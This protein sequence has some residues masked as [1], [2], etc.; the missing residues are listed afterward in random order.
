MK[1][2]PPATRHRVCFI[3]THA[4]RR[5]GIG[6]FTSDLAN[7]VR[8][9]AES[10]DVIAINEPGGRHRYRKEV[11]YQ[12]PEKKVCAYRAA[13][14]YLNLNEYSI[15]C[16]Q[17]EYGI[18]GGPA[19]EN[20][21]QL[22]RNLRMPLVTTL[23]TLLEDPDQEQ[24]DVL[25]EIVQLSQR[26]V[27]MSH[28]AKA[29]LQRLHNVDPRRIDLVP[30]GA[31]DVEYVEPSAVKHLIGAEGRTV[32]LTF[33]L[34][35]PDKGIEYVIESLPKLVESHPDLLY[36]VLGATH[37]NVR[38]LTNDAYRKRLKGLAKS[39]GIA[40][41][42][43]FE[44]RFVELDVLV[45]FLQAADIYVTPY[46]KPQ[47]ITSGTLSYAFACG[48]PIVSTPYWHAAELLADERGVLVPFRDASAVEGAIHGL[49]ED[50]DKLG[51]M[52]A[53]A[54]SEGRGTTWKAIGAKYSRIFD[55][56]SHESRAQLPLIMSGRTNGSYSPEPVS[57]DIR[58]MAAMTDDTGIFQHA[59][60]PVPNRHEGYCVD[61]N[62]RALLVCSRLAK[63][64]MSS[65]Q[66]DQL[67]VTYLSFM[68]HAWNH[69]NGRFRNFMTFG[70][71][72]AE[73]FGSEDSHGRS[74]WGLGEFVASSAHQDLRKVAMT[75]LDKALKS[76]PEFTSPRAWAYS[77][78]GI[79]QDGSPL[80][81]ETLAWEI[82]RDL[83]NR[84]LKLYNHN[85]AEDW[86]WFEGYV[87]YDNARLSQAMICAGKALDDQ[88]MVVVGLESLEWICAHQVGPHGEF[89]PIGSDHVWHQ[90]QE[91][92][93][94]DHQP[95]EA[96]GIVDACL[97]AATV[98]RGMV[99]LDRAKWAA[100]WFTGRNHL[101]QS[102]VDF[103]TG[104]CRD[105]I[106]IDRLNENQG[107]E[108]TLAYIGATARYLAFTNEVN[109]TFVESER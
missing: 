8:A 18:F 95:L 10:A 32:I 97:E 15:V 100:E 35:S 72:W 13:A 37:P 5:C 96:W 22:L 78:I 12:I 59:V 106:H 7:C 62:A 50:R 47:Q 46:L 31:P 107:A 61:D 3:G 109:W 86:K 102:V 71:E 28:K 53:R 65:S 48:K 63:L 24:R 60:G 42:V 54:Y 33:G 45:K 73:E 4:P 16:L 94:F 40:D 17:H 68:H 88:K 25:E 105:G 93:R 90:H 80:S 66:I 91:K 83:S 58:H 34:L 77:I 49:L 98:D 21:L 75:T 70:R 9:Y 76:V 51:Q 29:I 64:G 92:P 84:L 2:L 74:I 11:V 55:Q 82:V 57:V 20:I 52:A 79:G 67:V 43:R 41:H 104:G 6:T 103:R 23:H 99:W 14:D 26:V 101:Q 87:S 38:A 85:V 36:I 81:G 27:V 19:G 56:A 108:S 39:L 69:G 1:G 89:F 30:H 44:D